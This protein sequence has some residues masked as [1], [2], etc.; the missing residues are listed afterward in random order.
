[1]LS[2]PACFGVL[3]LQRLNKKLPFSNHYISVTAN[4]QQSSPINIPKSMS[5]TLQQ[6]PSSSITVISLKWMR[7]VPFFCF[8]TALNNA[9][10][11]LKNYEFIWGTLLAWW[12]TYFN[13][14]PQFKVSPH[15]F[16]KTSTCLK[17]I[18]LLIILLHCLNIFCCLTWLVI[19]SVTL[20]PNT[21]FLQFASCHE[22][23]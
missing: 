6:H 2:Q 17:D 23:D 13:H 11:T 10:L 16:R 15:T 21:H 12:E 9:G 18:I 19:S 7:A 22:S 4:S 5:C 1:M 8:R 14:R 20:G 3:H